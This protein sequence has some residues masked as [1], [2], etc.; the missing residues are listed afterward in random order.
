MYFSIRIVQYHPVQHFG[1]H[2]GLISQSRFPGALSEGSP[3]GGKHHIQEETKVA[4]AALAS[5]DTI[6]CLHCIHSL[7]L[8]CL[9]GIGA[10]G[11][12]EGRTA[13][14]CLRDA[15]V[16]CPIAGLPR[17]GSCTYDT[18]GFM[19]TGIYGVLGATFRLARFGALHAWMGGY[20]CITDTIAVKLDRTLLRLFSA[21]EVG[22]DGTMPGEMDDEMFTWRSR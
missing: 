13:S 14:L 11:L 20:F 18:H 15:A 7:D 6:Q 5:W 10:L 17:T 4:R 3:L 19:T 8:F 22:D 16:L 1:P 21:A 9:F 12:K 2:R